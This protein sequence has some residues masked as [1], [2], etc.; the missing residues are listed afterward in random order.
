MEK[1][2]DKISHIIKMITS[3][4]EQIHSRNLNPNQDGTGWNPEIDGQDQDQ[5]DQLQKEIEL[6]EID[7]CNR[8]ERMNL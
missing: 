1:D 8:I 7:K 4:G 6:E 3:I 5:E 2:W